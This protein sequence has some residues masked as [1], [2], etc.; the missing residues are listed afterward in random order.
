MDTEVA[1]GAVAK[2][3]C[4]LRATSRMS[5]GEKPVQFQY[6]SGGVDDDGSV[7]VYR[8]AS[9][10]KAIT[11]VAALQ[12]MEEGVFMLTEPVNKWIPELA[13]L[14]V[15]DEQG[16]L[17]KNTTSITLKSLLNHTSGL[18]YRFNTLATFDP[19]AARLEPY[20]ER[21]DIFDIPY[22]PEHTSDEL[23]R[24]LSK[25]PL[26]FT[27]G[28]RFM[29][30]LSTDVLG[31]LISRALGT[32]LD[33]VLKER[34][35][36]PL[37]MRHTSHSLSEIEAHA[38]E[39]GDGDVQLNELYESNEKKQVSG[40]ERWPPPSSSPS[41]LDSVAALNT[42]PAAASGGAEWCDDQ[43]AGARVD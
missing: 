27:P 15:F 3:E 42:Q 38:S 1:R 36:E 35:F 4:H 5:M 32:P 13:D 12:L 21:H 29:Y 2:A 40:G 20:Y 7:Q 28:S 39:A 8:I 31:I 26:A 9:M 37:N 41:P 10:T 30:S 43:V 25:C 33:E 19:I 17:K 23:L 18:S 22:K 24:R 6:T 16:N 34:I 11:S 14:Q